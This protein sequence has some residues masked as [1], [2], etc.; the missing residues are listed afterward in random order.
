MV[1]T[2]VLWLALP[3][4]APA[5]AGDYD[6]TFS[7]D[8]IFDAG[9]PTT[10][11]ILVRA[12]E[13][14]VLVGHVICGRDD[15][16][17]ETGVVQLRPGGTRDRSFGDEG[18]T[19]RRAPPYVEDSTQDALLQRGRVVVVGNREFD[20]GGSV[21][22]ITRLTVDGRFDRDFSRDGV[23]HLD[24]GATNNALSVLRARKGKLLVSVTS[25]V[26]NEY[27]PWLVRLLPDGSLDRSFS[28]DG[29]RPLPSFAGELHRLPSGK[30]MGLGSPHFRLNPDLS[31]DKGYGRRGFARPIPQ[32]FT[33]A[34]QVVDEGR[35]VFVGQWR[36]GEGEQVGLIRWTRG[37]AL[38]LSFDGD[39]MVTTQLGTVDPESNEDPSADGQGVVVDRRGRL[40]VNASIRYFQDPDCVSRYDFRPAI[41]RYT[42]DGQLDST[43]GDGGVV[44]TPDCD[45]TYG[46]MRGIALQPDG[47][48]LAYVSSIIRL[49]P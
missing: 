38:D 49:L 42:E 41:L 23:R 3:Q 36:N 17:Y 5:S 31:L 33:G 27:H 21:A 30:I 28:G 32:G 35:V 19:C 29:R 11:D 47:K 37:G 16:G 12:N 2:L 18:E 46:A 24:F 34:P 4:A 1:A 9:H 26:G 13:K 48:I 6:P 44:H 10:R 45:G 20:T 15:F 14:I 25:R 7:S 40:V 8:G 43:F 22:R 39:G